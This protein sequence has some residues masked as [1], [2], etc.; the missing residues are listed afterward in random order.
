MGI[1]SCLNFLFYLLNHE[2]ALKHAGRVSS[3]L[4]QYSCGFGWPDTWSVDIGLRAVGCFASLQIHS[5][6]PRSAACKYVIHVLS[7]VKFSFWPP[8][9]F[10]NSDNPSFSF[11]VRKFHSYEANVIRKTPLRLILDLLQNF[12]K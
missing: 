6:L 1:V 9:Y 10:P 8:F 3:R 12:I 4:G 2:Q 7:G 5:R 11:R